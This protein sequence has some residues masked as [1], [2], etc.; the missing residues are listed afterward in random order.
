MCEGSVAMVREGTRADAM[1]QHMK[2]PRKQAQERTV[3]YQIHHAQTEFN[4]KILAHVPEV[5]LR[6]FQLFEG[7]FVRTIL[8]VCANNICDVC[9]AT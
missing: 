7:S 6:G 1:S 2:E 8:M 4:Q 9:C 5:T 3:H